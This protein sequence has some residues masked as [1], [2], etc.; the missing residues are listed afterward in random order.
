MGHPAQQRRVTHLDTWGAEPWL[1]SIDEHNARRPRGDGRWGTRPWERGLDGEAH[2]KSLRRVHKDCI[3][4]SVILPRPV[5]KKPPTTPPAM[6][7]NSDQI[8]TLRDYATLRLLVAELHP[9]YTQEA[10]SFLGLLPRAVLSLPE[11]DLFQDDALEAVGE[12]GEDEKP[13]G[14]DGIV[15]G[16]ELLGRKD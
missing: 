16:G 2:E 3:S 6:S 4:R 15:H 7:A 8:T 11:S 9:N 12:L 5:M 14:C 13:S 10:I 1:V